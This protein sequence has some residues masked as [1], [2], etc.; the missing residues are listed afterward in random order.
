M[1]YKKGRNLFIFIALLL[2]KTIACALDY[3]DTYNSLSSSFSSFVDPNEGLTSFPSLNIT[4]GGREESLGSAFTGVADDICFFDYNPAASCVLENTEVAV[5]HNAWIADS[6]VETLAGT[7]RLGNLGLGAKIKCFYVPFTEYNIFGER[8]AGNYYSETTG[9]LNV[10]YNFFSGYYFKGL[11]TGINL[12]TAW[13]S[14]PDYTD[15][16]TNAIIKDS[17]IQQSGLAFMADLGVLLRFNVMKMYNS[18][19]PN[20]KIGLSLLNFGTAITGFQSSRG[21]I[22]D[23]PLPSAASVGFSYRLFPALAFNAE[24][25]QPVNLEDFSKSALWSLGGG[26]EINVTDF[27]AFLTGFRLKGGNPR[28]SLGT[29]FKLNRFIFDLN[30]TFDLTS[31]INPV[32]HFS[33]STRINLGDRGRRI[34]RDKCDE[35]YCAGLDEYAAGNLDMAVAYWKEALKQDPGFDPARRW[36]RTVENSRRLY[37]RVLDMQNLDSL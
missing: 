3:T 34:K 6:N 13:R 5:F 11:A 33:L 24:F 32:N 30:Y 15:N 28:F 26:V 10:S 20:L 37:N 27:F 29:E 31:S 36:I 35:L 14:I 1:M 25:R 8:V 23:D 16:D 22:K 4:S 12:K 2:I 18:R 19:D 21:I 7:I 9:T 17:G